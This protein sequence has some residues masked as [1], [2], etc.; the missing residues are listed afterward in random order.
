MGWDWGEGDRR[1]GQ[2]RSSK[3]CRVVT[4]ADDRHHGNGRRS[5]PG[6]S[7]ARQGVGTWRH[8]PQDGLD[9]RLLAELE[10]SL[11]WVAV[12]DPDQF[13]AYANALG[14]SKLAT[15]Q[16]LLLRSY[17]AASNLFADEAIEYL[18]EDSER[19]FSI[20]YVST[21]SVD[22]VEQLVEVVTP[23]CSSANFGG[24]E[25]AI[26]GY[27]PER[28]RRADNRRRWGVSQL[29]LLRNLEPSRLSER[30]A[31]RLQ[32]LHRK[33]EDAGPLERRSPEG[34]RVTSPIPESSASKMND[35]EWLGAIKHYSSDSPSYEPGEIPR[36]GGSR[37]ISASPKSD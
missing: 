36:R 34:G 10:S 11:S 19:R 25:Q 3:I 17:A 29:R 18:L 20:G 9:N 21:S 7:V 26:L 4:S 13:R 31:R 22:A 15:M 5:Q 27:Y 14:E 32:E 6:P 16:N 28:E 8:S 24:L 35:D 23:F 12:N 33:F 1:G 2:R 37:A 30:G